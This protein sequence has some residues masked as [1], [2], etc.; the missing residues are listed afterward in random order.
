MEKIKE[1][2]KAM[3][4]CYTTKETTE[5]GEYQFNYLDGD[6]Y[7]RIK[8]YKD[9]ELFAT[10]AEDIAANTILHPEKLERKCEEKFGWVNLKKWA[11]K[12]ELQGTELYDYLSSK[13][14]EEGISLDIL[15]KNIDD[16][17]RSNVDNG[18]PF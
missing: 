4:K 5:A 16:I 15:D 14:V 18:L 8:I 12:S 9:G 7:R 3:A 10:T 11:F 1:I 2:A 17:I 6:A 13:C